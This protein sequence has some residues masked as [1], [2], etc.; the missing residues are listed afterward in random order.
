MS[1]SVEVRVSKTEWQLL[2]KDGLLPFEL[3]RIV[4]MATPLSHGGY[5]LQIP[6]HCIDAFRGALTEGLA[7]DGF[8]DDYE[9]TDYGRM[10]EDL[11]DKLFV[12]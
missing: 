1:D 8:D 4:G 9:P 7:K 3:Q 10:L 11:L 6:H 5:V 12:P 2:Q